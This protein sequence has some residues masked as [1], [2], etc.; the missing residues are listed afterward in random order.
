MSNGIRQA[1]MCT[2]TDDESLTRYGSENVSHGVGLFQQRMCCV[3]VKVD[4]KTG[5]H[6]I[7]S[8]LLSRIGLFNY[9][10]HRLM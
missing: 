5:S 2:S 7:L 3:G 1:V 8:S 6:T 9:P 10:L 4:N